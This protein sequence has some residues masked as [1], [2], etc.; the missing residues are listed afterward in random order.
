MKLHN[1]PDGGLMQDRWSAAIW[2]GKSHVSDEHVGFLMDGSGIRCARSVMPR[3]V[4]LTK[5]MAAA[6]DVCPGGTSHQRPRANV[7]AVAEPIPDA[8][9]L[10]PPPQPA[11]DQT[12][13]WQI[14]KEVWQEYG[15]TPGCWKC[16]DWSRNIRS[17]RSHSR[18]CRDRLERILRAH[19]VFGPRIAES[20]QRAEVRTAARAAVVDE[21][22]QM[23]AG[24]A[25]E[26]EAEAEAEADGAVAMDVDAQDV[27]AA[28][29]MDVDEAA[30]DDVPMHAVVEDP[31]EDL[32]V[33]K[34]FTPDAHADIW[35][36]GKLDGVTPQM[37]SAAKQAE[38]AQL[39]RRETFEVR[40][41]HALSP[42][43]KTIGTR[44]VITN[45]GTT[46]SPLVKARLVCQE[47]ATYADPDLFS[48]TPGLAA[49]K[50]ILA[51]LAA[52][53]ASRCLMLLDITGAFLYGDM[54]REVAITLPSELGAQSQEVGLLKRSLYGLRDAPQIWQ[55]HIGGSLGLQ[56][57]SRAPRWWVF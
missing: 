46:E 42:G 21:A 11:V 57:S 24:D 39:R 29:A 8:R 41:R 44:W 1:H 27:D 49:V 31:N 2:L 6:V 17:R 5:E 16:T 19:P 15:S 20:N 50:C 10:P 32:D 30:G 33:S 13:S 35:E 40:S 4:Q 51:E 18:A 36:S 23:V 55:Q 54:R 52:A 34:W 28:T 7:Q 56:V 12:R 48:G 45:K 26:A 14:T 9:A 53:P 47:Y 25:V 37:V 38:L 43:V 22:P 3:D